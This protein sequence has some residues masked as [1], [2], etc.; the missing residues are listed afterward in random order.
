MRMQ[1]L[2]VSHELSNGLKVHLLPQP[3]TY[4]TT[5]NLL[6]AVGAK[7]EDPS[8]TGFAHL[9]EHLMFGGTIQAPSYDAIAQTMGAENNAF[10]TNDITNYYLTF[11]YNQ[12]ERAF[13]LEADR[14]R[15]LAINAKSLDVQKSVVIEEFKQRYLNQPYGD[16][17]LKLRPMVY[18]KHPYQWA[19]IGKDISHV[20]QATLEDV[21]TFYDTY[22]RPNN[23]ILTIAGRFDS[24][25]TLAWAE[26]YFGHL[27]AQSIPKLPSFEEPI[28][29][30]QKRLVVTGKVPNAQIVI[31]FKMCER[32]DSAY[33]AT[34]LL[35]NLLGFGKSSRLHRALV[36]E[37]AM[38][39]SIH[40]Y[41]LG[42]IG[43]GMFVISGMVLPQLP[44]EAAEAAIWETLEQLQNGFITDKEH[45]KLIHQVQTYM[46]FEHMSGQ[47]LA[48]NAAFHALIGNVAD[49]YEEVG[50]MGNVSKAAIH[51]VAQQLLTPASAS[52]IHYLPETTN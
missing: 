3:E 41:Q 30:Q 46:A 18:E 14:M 17:W 2:I 27:P 40:C 21:Q 11:P 29:T 45:E 38:F 49:V 22:Y 15:G 12:L 16:L 4:L 24:Q 13:W 5:F 50:I 39:S 31:A 23:A 47:S 25:Q 20:A 51:E 6:Y 35:S 7:H 8:L 10:T 33:Y 52:I 19:T 43:P 28:Q 1:N 26:K 32:T 37:K 34:D 42:S 44:V 9:F 36:V 48:M